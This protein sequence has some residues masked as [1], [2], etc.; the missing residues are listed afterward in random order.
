M[1]T[2]RSSSFS[3]FTTSLWNC[4]PLFLSLFPVEFSSFLFCLWPLTPQG[5]FFLFLCL[6][7]LIHHGTVFLFS[8]SL[9]LYRGIST[10]IPWNFLPLSLAFIMKYS[11][12]VFGLH[13]ETFF[14]FLC[15]WPSSWNFLPLPLTLAFIV[16]LSS[17]PLPLAFI[18]KLSFSS[19]AFGLH[20]ETFFPFLCLWPSS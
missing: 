3:V 4:L 17:P 20:R 5:T 7:P 12:S 18:V 11:S 15:L 2:L 10:S 16:E 13:R 6:W 8:V 9:A 19:S 14:P 1:C